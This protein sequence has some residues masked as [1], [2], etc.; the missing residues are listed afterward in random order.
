MQLV[1]PEIGLI[2]WMLISFGIIVF[3][4]AKYAWP[5]I[6]TALDE[7]EKSIT[8][9][10]DSARKAKDDVAALKADNEKILAEARNVRDTM[11]KEAR[12]T[13]DKIVNEAKA[14]ATEESDRLLKLARESIQNEKMAAIT[15]LKNQVAQLSVD[16]AQKLLTEELSSPE[17]QK[18][19]VKALLENVNLN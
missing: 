9:A 8:E 5:V 11:L 7:R 10:L 17:K 18:T 14:K 15:E 6:L 13:K 12:E 3:L 19:L 1:K 2:V 16:I 4:L